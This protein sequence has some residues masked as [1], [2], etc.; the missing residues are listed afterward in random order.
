VLGEQGAPLTAAEAPAT[1]T[2][3][4]D[5]SG[6][7]KFPGI[8]EIKIV[9][10]TI[11]QAEGIL[12][13]EYARLFEDPFVTLTFSNKR[14]TVLGASGGQVIPLVNENMRLTEVLALS[15]GVGNDAKANNIRLLRE[16]KVFLVDFSTF[17]GYLKNNMIVEP[18][19]IVYVEPIRRPFLEGLRDYGAV[20]SLVTSIGAI[21]VVIIQ[22]TK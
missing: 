14:V 20:I 5:E 4:V 16:D 17:D 2:Y 12:Q 18:G 15:K 19:D 8:E 11:R 13:K 6:K 3:L 22:A 7:V 10:L 21:V 1:R 9:G